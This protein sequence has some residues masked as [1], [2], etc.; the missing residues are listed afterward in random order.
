M[1][2]FQIDN[3]YDRHVLDGLVEREIPREIALE[4][5]IKYYPV[6]VGHFRKNWDAIE[7]IDIFEGII[8]NNVSLDDVKKIL[9]REKR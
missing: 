6:V 8:K 1:Y 9:G 3:P 5:L 2:T 7:Y 4:T